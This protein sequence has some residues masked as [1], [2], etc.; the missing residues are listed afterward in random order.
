MTNLEYE[1]LVNKHLSRYNY[2]VTFTPENPTTVRVYN[3]Y[4]IYMG[5]ETLPR[6]DTP[7]KMAQV[8]KEHFQGLFR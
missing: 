6:E 7:E 5:R 1:N 4:G 8:I 3:I 2:K